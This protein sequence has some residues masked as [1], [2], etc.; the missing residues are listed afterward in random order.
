M[1]DSLRD[2]RV[3]ST[4]S[5][6]ILHSF[7]GF[8]PDPD[9]HSETIASRRHIL[10]IPAACSH[11]C[12]NM[13]HHTANSVLHPLLMVWDIHLLL[14]CPCSHLPFFFQLLLVL[15]KPLKNVIG[16]ECFPWVYSLHLPAWCLLAEE[17]CKIHLKIDTDWSHLL[18][19]KGTHC[20]MVFSFNRLPF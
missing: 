9:I 19:K 15:L 5:T 18:F 2:S 13:H 14:I 3:T 1:I 6:S 12:H 17:A 4:Q 7:L 10:S 16:S 11:R 20:L 8:H